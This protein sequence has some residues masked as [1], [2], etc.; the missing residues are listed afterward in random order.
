M[1]TRKHGS[2]FWGYTVETHQEFR[3]KKLT[4]HFRRMV[5]ADPARQLADEVRWGRDAE[6]LEQFQTAVRLLSELG[7]PYYAA[8][9]SGGRDSVSIQWQANPETPE[10]FYGPRVSD[11][12]FSKQ[13][14]T[15]LSRLAK[16]GWDCKPAD[17]IAA[18][19]AAPVEYCEA[20]RDWIPTEPKPLTKSATATESES[21]AA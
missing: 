6:T 21:S 1:K 16:L 4:L 8:S 2:T 3:F 11:C 9:T 14:A 13:A 5:A 12:G 20:L 15:V 18:L 17:A 7:L 19:R 10:D